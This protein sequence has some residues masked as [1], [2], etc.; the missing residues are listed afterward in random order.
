M[1]DRLNEFLLMAGHFI[2]GLLA[3]VIFAVAWG[4]LA[5]LSLFAGFL[6]ANAVRLLTDNAVISVFAILAG[7]TLMGLFFSIYVWGPY[8]GPAVFGVLETVT[9]RKV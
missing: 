3:L 7:A 9:K 1:L 5:I 6:A 2:S 8:I 4:A